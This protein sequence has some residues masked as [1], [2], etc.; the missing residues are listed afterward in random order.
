ML[1]CAIGVM[2]TVVWCPTV[3]DSFLSL[4]PPQRPVGSV[5][6]RRAAA[7]A[8]F[9]W[10]CARP[11]VTHFLNKPRLFVEELSK[12]G[13][14]ICSLLKFTE[15]R[16]YPEQEGRVLAPEPRSSG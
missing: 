8:P 1:S 2:R 6:R 3:L 11:K 15:E 14:V 4:G 13:G 10:P 9:C 5:K 12:Y 7:P 16:C